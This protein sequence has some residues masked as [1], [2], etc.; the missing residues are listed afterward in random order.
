MHTAAGVSSVVPVFVSMAFPWQPHFARA[1]KSHDRGR[2]RAAL[3]HYQTAD[4]MDVP[5]S[6]AE[7]FRGIIQ[8]ERR[9]CHESGA[10]ICERPTRTGEEYRSISWLVGISE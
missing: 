9:A 3:K 1:P 6:I 2:R 10:R 4:P 7:P 8:S 5:V